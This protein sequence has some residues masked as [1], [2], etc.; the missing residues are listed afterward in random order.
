M[1]HNYKISQ[2]ASAFIVAESAFHFP[3]E[4]GG[5]LIG[6]VE[7]DC[8][9]I[10]AATGPGPDAHHTSTRFKRD[11]DYSQ[12]I[13]DSIVK[14]S[15]GTIDYIG[16]WHSHPYKSQPSNTDINSMKWIA[17]HEDYAIT[18]PTMLLCVCTGHNSWKIRCY[19][20]FNNTINLLET[21]QKD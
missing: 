17:S 12:E 6:K 18:E 10:R 11:G 9:M 19:S 20:F 2:E 13:L 4:T 8:V 15:G 21:S 14:Q 3:N 5:L 7:S 16:E 1:I